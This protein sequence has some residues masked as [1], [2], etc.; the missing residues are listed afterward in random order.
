ERRRNIQ[1]MERR[2]ELL[3]ACDL[4]TAS[5]APLAKIAERLG[6]PAAVIPNSINGEQQ[7]VA[8]ELAAAPPGRGEGVLVGYFSGSATHQRDFAEC[9]AALLDILE[10]YPEVRFRLVGY[11]ALGPGWERHRDRIEHSGF[12]TPA[13][14]LRCIAAIDSNLAPLDPG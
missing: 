12:L 5:T 10:Q 6:R 4:V 9:E 3:R 14:V 13:D 1:A 8:A 11:L 7:R 2:R